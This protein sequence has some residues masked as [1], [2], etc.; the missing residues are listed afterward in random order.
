MCVQARNNLS[1]CY[2]P[3]D[4]LLIGVLYKNIKKKQASESAKPMLIIW[5]VTRTVN[6]Q[7]SD[8]KCQDTKFIHMQPVK[9]VMWLAKPAI[10]QSNC[11]KKKYVCDDKNC[12]SAQWIHMWPAMKSSNMQSVTNPKHLQLPKPAM[13]QSI[14]NKFHQDD[15][16]CQS[17]KPICCDKKC[18]VKSEGTQFSHMWSMPKTASNQIGT[19]PEVTRN[20]QDSTSKHC[21]PPRNEN[22]CSDVVKNQFNHMWP[23]TAVS[24]KSQVNTKLQIQNKQTLRPKLEI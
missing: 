1:N 9:P 15:K 4:I 13:K 18:Q 5:K 17:T 19:Q 10:L 6:L 8:K 7:C 14:D 21:Y 20:C 2:L 16:N 22:V 11:K 24:K 23:V 3:K 12:Q